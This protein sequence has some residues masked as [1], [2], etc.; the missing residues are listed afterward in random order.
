[1]AQYITTHDTTETQAASDGKLRRRGLVAGAAALVAGLVAKAAADAPPVAALQGQPV[2][3]GQNNTATVNT[4]ISAIAPYSPS[5]GSVFYADASGAGA[6]SV[7]GIFAQGSGNSSGI[8]SNGGTNGGPGVAGFGG[9]GTA[10]GVRGTASG[11]GSGVAGFGGPNGGPGLFALGGVKGSSTFSGGGVF[12]LVAGAFAPLSGSFPPAG[13]FG[14]GRGVGAI[15]VRA[16]SD[17]NYGLLATSDTAQAVYVT[18]GSTTVASL[19]ARGAR[20]GSF[21][22]STNIG[23]AASDPADGAIGQSN[24]GPNRNGVRGITDLGRGVYGAASSTGTGVLGQSTSGVGV[25]GISGG[26]SGSGAQPYG[27]A[28]S[29]TSAPGFGLFGVTSVAGTVGFAGGAAVAG[30]IAGQFSGPVNIYNSVPGAEGNL[31]VQNNFQVS[32][33]KSAAVP[34][35]DG[36]HRLLYC[37][38]SP[39]SWF[40][41]FGEGTITG[42]K[43]EVKL[44]PDFAAVVDTSKLHV[45]LT[46]HDETHHL[47]VKT[48]SGSGF[49]VA[50]GVSGDATARGV[51]AGDVNGTFTYRVVAK[52]KDVAAE[53]LAK[54]TMPQEIKAPALVLPN[55]PAL[56]TPSGGTKG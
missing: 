6:N 46:P 54:F 37:M 52:R 48:R 44:D 38:E 25:L 39:E 49:A 10:D 50:A 33:T 40:E 29:V 17:T 13:V 28:G 16:D 24:G 32:G 42:G 11:G 7:I 30:A 56:P 45:F 18:S 34:H 22:A 14:T 2:I 26:G 21:S 51:K 20:G 55:P 23:L 43:A 8:S 41:D 15:G 47:A 31:Y 4:G 9:G 53:R 12:G 3:A 36:I 27:V 19:D 5:A 1:M 35:P